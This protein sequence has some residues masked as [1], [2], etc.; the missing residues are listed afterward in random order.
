MNLDNRIKSIINKRTTLHLS[1]LRLESLKERLKQYYIDERR[2][3][4]ALQKEYDDIV[5]MERKSIGGIFK[6]VL[7]SREEQFEIER[8]E[9]LQA[10]LNHKECLKEIK[11]LEFEKKI[12]SEKIKKLPE[13]ER[14]Y[15]NLLKMRENQVL[16]T[17]GKHKAAIKQFDRQI[18]E[19]IE[20]KREIYEAKIVGAKI[21]VRLNKMIVEL[22]KAAESG[23]WSIEAYRA[24]GK[25]KA[26]VQNAQKL[27]YE[28]KSLLLS[29]KSELRDIYKNRKIR[30]TAGLKNFDDISKTYYS[31][32]ISDWVVQK[33]IHNALHNMQSLLDRLVRILQ[34][35]ELE[36][37]KADQTIAYAKERKKALLLDGLK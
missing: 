10:V 2:L 19:S 8:Q 36:E 23:I 3:K 32:L 18:D 17:T 31:N 28:I 5:Q 21:Q 13:V 26:H 24:R 6:K 14:E 37:K 9:Y 11:L 4:R 25:N 34:A 15:D 7:K 20:L 29:F 30:F 35:L 33:T 22:N 12:L 16:T 27:F 1:N